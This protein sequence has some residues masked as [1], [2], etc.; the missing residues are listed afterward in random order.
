MLDGFL[1]HGRTSKNALTPLFI[2]SARFPVSIKSEEKVPLFLIYFSTNTLLT[3]QAGTP[4]EDSFHD[5]VLATASTVDAA[6]LESESTTIVL[7]GF[8]RGDWS[9]T[10]SSGSG[11]SGSD[12]AALGLSADGVEL[13]RW[14][15][16]NLI[17]STPATALLFLENVLNPNS[18]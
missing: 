16:A 9:G 5:A 13:W 12:F 15:V 14:Q 1:F 17:L 18:E 7:A 3:F 2:I 8:T 6:G 4:E 11:S 10:G